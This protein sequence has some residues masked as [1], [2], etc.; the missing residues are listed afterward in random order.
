MTERNPGGENLAI[1]SIMSS[2]NFSSD[3]R[4]RITKQRGIPTRCNRGEAASLF[5]SKTVKI[6][7]DYLFLVQWDLRSTKPTCSNG[8][9]S[10]LLRKLKTSM[11]WLTCYSLTISQFQNSMVACETMLKR[12]ESRIEEIELRFIKAL[13]VFCLVIVFMYLTYA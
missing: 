2:V 4:A 10:Q 6:Q 7:E 9:I 8:L 11:N 5:T 13:F 12:Q 3:T 1:N